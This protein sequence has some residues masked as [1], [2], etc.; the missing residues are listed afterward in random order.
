MK[1]NLQRLK[2][3]KILAQG[4]GHTFPGPR[5]PSLRNLGPKD[6]GR[7]YVLRGGFALPFCLPPKLNPLHALADRGISDRHVT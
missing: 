6:R 2:I 3:K 7:G 5:S 4:K 1:T